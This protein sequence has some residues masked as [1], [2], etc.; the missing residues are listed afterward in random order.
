MRLPEQFGL[1][2]A[3]DVE[4]VLVDEGDVAVNIRLRGRGLAVL[5]YILDIGNGQIGTHTSRTPEKMAN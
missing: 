1:A 3:A 5:Q 4:E 2:V